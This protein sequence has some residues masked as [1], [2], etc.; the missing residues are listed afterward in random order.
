VRRTTCVLTSSCAIG[1]LLQADPE[2]E[3]E[4][5]ASELAVS[6]FSP[7]ILSLLTQRMRDCVVGR[8]W[9]DLQEGMYERTRKAS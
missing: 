7:R 2:K 6:V 8:R 1:Q 5:G 9:R 3:K 4:E